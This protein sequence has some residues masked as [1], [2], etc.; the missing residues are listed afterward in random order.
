[1]GEKS[2]WMG[3]FHPFSFSKDERFEIEWGYVYASTARRRGRFIQQVPRY[4]DGNRLI[5]TGT[6][7]EATKKIEKN[8]AK[9]IGS[10]KLEIETS[11][12]RTRKLEHHVVTSDGTVLQG[13]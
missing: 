2:P 9:Y 1:M 5:S 10:D 4:P 13:A 8:G 11:F 6:G 12:K 7:F 3:V